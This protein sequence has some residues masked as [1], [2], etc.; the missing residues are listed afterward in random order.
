MVEG[1][2]SAYGHGCFACG[3]DNPTGL[4]LD[5]VGVEDDEIVGRF[6]PIEDHQGSPA[7]LHGGIAATALDEILVWAAIAFEG[8]MSVTG[9]LELKFRRPVGVSEPIE[10]RGRVTE[11][12]GRRLVLDGRLVVNDA[13]AVEAHGLYLVSADVADILGA[14]S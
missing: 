1:I 9:S 8:V 5:L 13:V 7:A 4:H 2:Q 11:R 3:R 6:V 14:T 10:L 12:R